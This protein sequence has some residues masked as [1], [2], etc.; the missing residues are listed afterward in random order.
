MYI[1]LHYRRVSKQIYAVYCSEDFI[2]EV[3]MVKGSWR[4]RTFCS[5]AFVSAIP[6]PTRYLAVVQWS[7]LKKIEQNQYL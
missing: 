6:A 7:G 4:F 1:P 2:G 3:C 5:P